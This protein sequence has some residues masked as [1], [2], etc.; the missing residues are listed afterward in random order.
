MITKISIIKKLKS[1]RYR[2]YSRKKDKKGKRRN[3]G[4]FDS[5]EKAKKHERAVSFFKYH[6]DDQSTR[7]SE[8]KA[9]SLISDTAKYLEEA[10]Y[11]PQANEMYA[12]MDAIDNNLD[13]ED[14]A[15]DLIPSSQLNLENEGTMG[16][17]GGTGGSASMFNIQEAEKLANLANKLDRKGLYKEADELDALIKQVAGLQVDP[18]DLRIASTVKLIK[19]DFEDGK[20]SGLSAGEALS[21]LAKRLKMNINNYTEGGFLSGLAVAMGFLE[22]QDGFGNPEVYQSA[23]L[24]FRDPDSIEMNNLDFLIGANG[25]QGITSI[26]GGSAGQFQGLSDSYFYSNYENQEGPYKH[27]KITI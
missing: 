22:P 2:L 24:I 12:I 25:L 10:G 20:F 1:G 8:T 3:L 18:D 27:N 17:L 14:N 26:D 21:V 23:L 4:T 19:Q 15:S 13:N 9:L 6:A 5:L 7:N 11:I 16:G